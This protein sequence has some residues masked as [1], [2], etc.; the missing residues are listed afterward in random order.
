[1]ETKTLKG[2]CSEIDEILKDTSYC[3]I[4]QEQVMQIVHKVFG[5]TMGQADMFRRAIGKKD[6]V[7]MQKMISELQKKET[8]LK[9]EDVQHIVET[10]AACSGYLFNKC[11]VGTEK[12]MSVGNTRIMNIADMYNCK[13]NLQWA[14]EHNKLALRK[15]YKTKGYG[16]SYSLDDN[17]KLVPNRIK[18]IVYSGTER[19]LTL[20]TN[21]GDITCTYNHKFPTPKGGM[22]AGDIKVGD[23]LYYMGFPKRK[24]YGFKQGSYT[25]IPQ[26]GQ[27]G[28]QEKP[29][30]ASRLFDDF[31]LNN[32][33]NNSPCEKCS[34]AKK[35]MEGHHK[36]GDRANNT[37][38]NLEWLCVGCHKKEHYKNGRTIMGRADKSAETIT[39]TNILP[40]G[41]KEVYSVEMEAPYHT[42]TLQNRLITSNSH[43]A[44]Y[45]YTAYQTLF[46]KTFYPSEFYCALLNSDI[47]AEKTSEYIFEAK[48]QGI[49]IYPPDAY[50]SDKKWKKDKEG[51]LRY[52]LEKIKNVGKA[53]FVYP[54]ISA[55]MTNEQKLITFMDANPTV[56]KQVVISMGKALCFGNCPTWVE[57]YVDWFKKAYSRKQECLERIEKFQDNPKKVSEWTEKMNSIESSPSYFEDNVGACVDAQTEV[58]GFSFL[59]KITAEYDTYL[60]DNYNDINIGELSQVRY[61]KTRAGKPM[62]S[63]TLTDR[64][65]FQHKYVM[66]RNIPS[67]LS[68]GIVVNVKEEPP[69]PYK[70]NSGFNSS[71]A[72]EVSRAKK[73]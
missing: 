60:A 42:F 34:K 61:I 55:D 27:K 12:I 20:Y 72:K 67:E 19:C 45:A 17:G 59:N 24:D 39:V 1:M 2:I 18:D 15:R 8:N 69:N 68:D 13:N 25:N 58:L 37:K 22:L 71:I 31:V 6:P 46:L 40:A 38:E 14:K 7:L 44:A 35:R 30:G 54:Q 29:D 56:N 10:I 23:E 41:Y 49:P 43:S 57:M 63:F 73:L 36:D 62:L 65:N 32:K 33:E 53:E 52:G 21:I 66:F 50:L 70:K 9:P 26:K 64:N 16:T 28:F 51:G 11:L 5:M 4:Y 48:C 47:D 3:I